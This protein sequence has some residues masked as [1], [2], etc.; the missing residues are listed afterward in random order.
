L[1]LLE[2]VNKRNNGKKSS[3]EEP[4]EL[5]EEK[6]VIK[7]KKEGDLLD[8]KSF[9]REEILGMLG[10][11]TSG[12]L[13]GP[14]KVRKEEKKEKE[15]I[16]SPKKHFFNKD[17]NSSESQETIA[18]APML[19]IENSPSTKGNDSP[20]IRWKNLSYIDKKFA[21]DIQNHEVLDYSQKGIMMRDFIKKHSGN[22]SQII[23]YGR[24]IGIDGETTF[25]NFSCLELAMKHIFIEMGLTVELRSV[26]IKTMRQLIE[27]LS[28]QMANL[29]DFKNIV[30][31]K[32]FYSGLKRGKLHISVEEF[33]GS[34]II[35]GGLLLTTRFDTEYH[36]GEWFSQFDL[37]VLLGKT[38]EEKI[39][40]FLTRNLIEDPDQSLKDA[41]I[42]KDLAMKS[43]D[44]EGLK[45]LII[46]DEITSLIKFFLDKKFNMSDG[47]K[48]WKIELLNR[49]SHLNS[50]DIE[51]LVIF[52]LT[53]SDSQKWFM[54][55][56]RE[57]FIASMRSRKI[58]TPEKLA[59]KNILGFPE[60]DN[61]TNENLEDII[62]NSDIRTNDLKE[63]PYLID[64]NVYIKLQQSSN[65]AKT[66]EGKVFFVPRVIVN[67]FSNLE[68][69]KDMFEERKFFI[70]FAS[71]NQI[72][73][74]PDSS[75]KDDLGDDDI[76]KY[77][78]S[79]VLVTFDNE[80]RS[81]WSGLKMSASQIGKVFFQTTYLPTKISPMGICFGSLYSEGKHVY[82]TVP[83]AVQ[84]YFRVTLVDRTDKMIPYLPPVDN[85]RDVKYTFKEF[86]SD[87]WLNFYNEIPKEFDEKELEVYIENNISR[88][89]DQYQRMDSEISI[90]KIKL[91]DKARLKLKDKFSDLRSNTVHKFTED[92]RFETDDEPDSEMGPFER[93]MDIEKDNYKFLERFQDSGVKVLR[94]FSKKE[95]KRPWLDGKP[96][97][98]DSESIKN[99][100]KRIFKNEFF[101][102]EKKETGLGNY[103]T[104]FSDD[105]E[106]VKF[107]CETLYEFKNFQDDLIG[108]SPE[109][110]SLNFEA[111]NM[112]LQSS[113]ELKDFSRLH[114]HMIHDFTRSTFPKGYVLANHNN[115]FSFGYFLHR[116]KPAR[117]KE[118]KKII[119]YYFIGNNKP[120]HF[121]PWHTLIDQYGKSMF[122]SRPY[123][124]SLSDV[125]YRSHLY[126]SLFSVSRF[127]QISMTKLYW[128][129]FFRSKNVS[130]LLSFFKFYNTIANSTYAKLDNLIKKY[131]SILPKR[132]TEEWL[133]DKVI[134]CIR[135]NSLGEAH[136][137]FGKAN[138]IHDF[139]EI[140]NL[141]S[142]VPTDITDSFAN[143]QSFFFSIQDNMETARK[144]FQILGKPGTVMEAIST[145][146]IVSNNS[147]EVLGFSPSVDV[148]SVCPGLISMALDEYK[149]T[150]TMP[151]DKE[152]MEE[153]FHDFESF[154]NTTT[155]GLSPK[156]YKKKTNA[157]IHLEMLELFHKE[158][159]TWRENRVSNK[160]AETKS[161]ITQRTLSE[162]ELDTVDHDSVLS[163]DESIY[164]ERSPSIPSV[165]SDSTVDLNEN[166]RGD[167]D[168]FNVFEYIEWC[169]D[170]LEERGACAMVAGKPQ[171]DASD[172]EIYIQE[173]FTKAGHFPIQSTFKTVNKRCPAE[174]V[175]KSEEQKLNSIANMEFSN[176]C[177]VN[178]DMEKW[179]PYDFKMKFKEGIQEMFDK[180]ML[181]F[182]IYNLLMRSLDSVDNFNIIFDSR[183]SFV[184]NRVWF[185]REDLINKGIKK[186]QGR[187]HSKEFLEKDSNKGSYFTLVPMTIGWP[188]GLMHN[189][190]SFFHVLK[191][192]A[193]KK[194]VKNHLHKFPVSVY[195]LAHSDDGNESL[196]A[197][198]EIR[199][200]DKLFLPTASAV[201]GNMLSLKQSSTKMS[202]STGPSNLT[203]GGKKILDQFSE[204]VSIYNMSGKIYNSWVRQSAEIQNSFT[205]SSYSQNNLALITRCMTIHSLSNQSLWPEIIYSFYL[206]DLQEFFF[207]E[208]KLVYDKTL[209]WCGD[210]YVSLRSL[211]KF[212]VWADNLMKFAINPGSIRAQVNNPVSEN[213]KIPDT[214]TRSKFLFSYKLKKM[215]EMFKN[216]DKDELS[217]IIDFEYQRM[218]GT[219]SGV[220]LKKSDSDFFNFYKHKNSKSLSIF[221]ER[222]NHLT[223][224]ERKEGGEVITLLNKYS[225]R[226][227]NSG[228]NFSQSIEKEKEKGKER[229]RTA[230]KVPE[231]LRNLKQEI[232]ELE[233]KGFEIT[234][235]DEAEKY[236]ED[237]DTDKSL[238][239]L[240]ETDGSREKQLYTSEEIRQKSMEI[241]HLDYV[242]SELIVGS[243]EVLEK[244]KEDCE[245]HAVFEM[246]ENNDIRIGGTIWRNR[247]T[248]P[249][250]IN[251]DFSE[252]C[253]LIVDPINFRSLIT[254]RHKYNMIADDINAFIRFY[255]I[256]YLSE[257]LS[258]AGNWD[259]LKLI[260]KERSNIKL[261]YMSDSSSSDGRFSQTTNNEISFLLTMIKF[262]LTFIPNRARVHKRNMRFESIVAEDIQSSTVRSFINKETIIV[263]RD[264]FPMI[265]RNFSDSEIVRLSEKTNNE[266]IRLFVSGLMGLKI[267][268]ADRGFLVIDSN[269]FNDET[270]Y[271]VSDGTDMDLYVISGNEIKYSDEMKPNLVHMMKRREGK[272][273]DKQ[274][275]V[276]NA[277]IDELRN[278]HRGQITFT[279]G[280]ISNMRVTQEINEKGFVSQVLRYSVSDAK[281]ERKEKKIRLNLRIHKG[282]EGKY[283]KNFL[284][285]K[286]NGNYIEIIDERKKPDLIDMCNTAGIEIEKF[287]SYSEK[288]FL[289]PTYDN[290]FSINLKDKNIAKREVLKN[291][292]EKIF[293]ILGIKP[294]F[295]EEHSPTECLHRTKD[296]GLP[297]FCLEGKG[298]NKILIQR[299]LKF[300]SNEIKMKERVLH[301][302]SDIN[303]INSN[304]T[305]DIIIGDKRYNLN[306]FIKLKYF[307]DNIFSQNFGANPD[308]IISIKSLR[309]KSERYI[310][311]KDFQSMV[312]FNGSIFWDTEKRGFKL[313]NKK[314]KINREIATSVIRSRMVRLT[315]SPILKRLKSYLI[316]SGLSKESC[317]IRDLYVESYNRMMSGYD[318]DSD[319]MWENHPET[320]VMEIFNSL[321]VNHIKD[322]DLYKIH[323]SRSSTKEGKRT[324]ISYCISKAGFSSPIFFDMITSDLCKKLMKTSEIPDELIVFDE[325][326]DFCLSVYHSIEGTDELIDIDQF[327]Q[328][329]TLSGL[330]N[331]IQSTFDFNINIAEA[332]DFF[333]DKHHL[334]L[335][336]NQKENVDVEEELALKEETWEERMVRSNDVNITDDNFLNG[337]FEGKRFHKTNSLEIEN[338]RYFL[339]KFIGE[340]Y[341]IVEKTLKFL[342]TNELSLSHSEH[343]KEDLE[344]FNNLSHQDKELNQ[345]RIMLEEHSI[346]LRQLSM[347]SDPFKR[348][349]LELELF[350]KICSVNRGEI[351]NNIEKEFFD[352]YDHGSMFLNEDDEKISVMKSEGNFF[353]SGFRNAKVSSAFNVPKSAN[354]KFNTR[355]P[356][357]IHDVNLLIKKLNNVDKDLWDQELPDGVKTK[358][359]ELKSSLSIILSISGMK[360]DSDKIE[361]PSKD[362]K[363]SF[364][365]V[366]MVIKNMT[367]DV[368]FK[369][370]N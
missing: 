368:Y 245:S 181:S 86:E 89:M 288:I 82:C 325:N 354:I 350:V 275:V 200:R 17:D 335:E 150:Y 196:S 167:T 351:F 12:S 204:L 138:N 234:H 341:H 208:K 311:E 33:S 15:K 67:E 1:R 258:N 336:S 236:L 107:N 225:V 332:V 177:Y 157:L 144:S 255:G 162:V 259:F 198:E 160:K 285:I 187:Y 343:L 130:K 183:M 62:H 26:K 185:S 129:L 92:N 233:S 18:E 329:K 342:K 110:T 103:K 319:F 206:N 293:S 267:S 289:Q 313:L 19:Y 315:V 304:L 122:I 51:I 70:S 39:N 45:N 322:T 156:D 16:H 68:K 270:V 235:K 260:G 251:S 10:K 151:T 53:I 314:E 219:K 180:K 36:T 123:A 147:P 153:M 158:K 97:K 221:S 87:N 184:K 353:S 352:K 27:D 237:I 358:L 190:S 20:D 168:I 42:L 132:R 81:K 281:G 80:L 340:G 170:K 240:E 50:A 121:Q 269:D 34:T 273:E 231:L 207:K 203:Y 8:K 116:S 54:I 117:T 253:D 11:L 7:K 182:N 361:I 127:E 64:T 65:Q 301:L 366:N 299:Y 284:H 41:E 220:F 230:K 244:I 369:E 362:S 131:L 280:F 228:K 224:L 78:N 120:K 243:N 99:F 105:K 71:V 216:S 29:E 226:T 283:L 316:K 277:E 367:G 300:F 125:I 210:K 262:K 93:Y 318:L 218:I 179:S 197:K 136:H 174:L 173:Y 209:Q 331:T 279:P 38:L 44:E 37:N 334:L 43:D 312:E 261:N 337:S 363:F 268:T 152:I 48:K 30:R 238:K 47:I 76:L 113:K 46:L 320:K 324:F 73:I 96:P 172:R 303:F 133:M 163:D 61:L 63:L 264:N 348:M 178:I 310:S 338:S 72:V 35:L 274:Y 330:S 248:T 102:F 360:L 201:I 254:K 298:P 128:T 24:K 111:K 98:E 88:Y 4:Q 278:F 94:Q 140:G 40:L 199:E 9:T 137:L 295:C 239:S 159:D 223:N 112:K 115:F 292:G 164:G 308:I 52:V 202:I 83:S 155:K 333:K 339:N 257:F 359:I 297:L 108:E 227:E 75:R 66:Y 247:L 25:F 211:S 296:R 355:D 282:T 345:I 13:S 22:E 124:I 242:V 346:N 176:S 250:A 126:N 104:C 6:G 106:K 205:F 256:N 186:S 291:I 56:D 305:T 145:K 119:Q 28:K 189:I 213:S 357:T 188:Q 175:S 2:I 323:E 5:G 142:F 364:R 232:R 290:F 49:C 3:L 306:Q 252:A 60:I 321:D 141:Y 59:L 57:S 58:V 249:F 101:N 370:Y 146:G 328:K 193:L 349:K 77:S 171:K 265:F 114:M 55:P 135:K 195:C 32:Y 149:E 21:I 212:G 214:K 143:Y 263:T 90:S 148:R 91:V 154:F 165:F 365:S 272:R 215:S 309:N 161:V 241:E 271:R 79:A 266:L 302:Q 84:E 276:D 246:N 134:D 191:G 356:V 118:K 69:K 169:L 294:F 222:R 100:R 307:Y 194:I 217:Q 327:G 317:L 192:C 85:F 286:R 109:M 344:H 326:C 23:Y 74:D 166:T 95:Q 287:L 14:D 31:I 139:L 347:I 229:S